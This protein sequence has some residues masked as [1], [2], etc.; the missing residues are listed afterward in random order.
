MAYING[1]EVLFSPIINLSGGEGEFDKGYS[2]GYQ[3]GLMMGIQE[4]KQA[5]Y[6][7]FWDA[8]QQ[9]GTRTDYQT[10]FKGAWWNDTIFKPKYDIA[11][12]GNASE[13]FGQSGV[14]DVKGICEGRGIKL[15]FSKVNYVSNPFN[16]SKVTRLP[17][18]DVSNIPNLTPLFNSAKELQW[19]D[20]IILNEDGSQQ[21]G[22]SVNYNWTL[23]S[24]KIVHL[25]IISGT[26][27]NNCYFNSQSL[28][29]KESIES[30]IN[31]LS[32]TTSGLSMILSKKAVNTAFETSAGA[33]DGSTSTEWANLSVP[34]SNW[35]ISLV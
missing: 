5:E 2:E 35:A 18:M 15:D 23:Y 27:G 10:A 29:D 25:P 6:D 12:V 33:A 7:A 8:Y 4:G 14:T 11:P 13:I 28:L 31:A 19:V 22:S 32:T 16:N 34:K 24:A 17:V 26:I 1:K 9:N 20:G 3:T 30:I 21:F